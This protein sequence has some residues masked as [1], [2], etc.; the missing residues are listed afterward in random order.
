M[1][2]LVKKSGSKE[3][4]SSWRIVTNWFQK[5]SA[6]NRV[7][8]YNSH[9]PISQKIAIVF[10]LVDRAIKLSNVCFHDANLKKVRKILQI[11]E[12]PTHLI[13]KYIKKRLAVINFS[14]NHNNTSTE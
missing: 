9:H 6:S 4:D 14:E 10:N 5:Q 7:I 11:N 3:I 2:V 1:F 8:D 12:Y 13:N